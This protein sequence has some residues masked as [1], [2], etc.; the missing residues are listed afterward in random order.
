MVTVLKEMKDQIETFGT[1]LENKKEPDENSKTEKR[2][3]QS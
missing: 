1:E 3:T 2:K